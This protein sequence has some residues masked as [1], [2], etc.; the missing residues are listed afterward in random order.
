MKRTLRIA[1]TLVVLALA[2]TYIL[3]KVDVRQSA[4]IFG[5]ASP[6][7]V[8]LSMSLIFVMIFPMAWRWQ[9]LL[10]ARGIRER[11]LWLARAYFVGFAV[12]QVLPT[13]VGGDA[14][15]IYETVR[16][17]PGQASPIAGSVLVERAL[18]GVVTLV[19]AG[20]G[21]LLAIGRFPIGA[22]LW[23]E[24]IF[25][26]GAI[27]LAVVFFSRRARQRLVILVPLTRRLRVE[28]LARA[29]YEGIH[30][31]RNHPGTLAFVALTTLVVQTGGIL[32]MYAAGRAVGIDVSLAAYIA[33]G[34]LLFLVTLVPFTINGLGVREAFF[35]SFLGKLDVAPEAAFAAGFLF[36]LTT[37]LLALP[38]LAVLLWD[39][40]RRDRVP[41]RAT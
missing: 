40:V 21:F 9:L 31:Y 19:L 37:V 5:E 14:S 36:F 25:A 27:V 16:R 32:S 41:G 7:W 17:H 18:G 35:V 4:Q 20:I 39:G 38:G 28:R 22:Y 23:I 8:V 24:F 13:S 1:A 10:R 11:V 3:L 30:G 6:L 34:P 26:F 12:G 2:L 33:F 29:L 15:R